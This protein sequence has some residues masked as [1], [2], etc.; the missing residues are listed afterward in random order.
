MKKL[1]LFLVI[2]LFCEWHPGLAQNPPPPDGRSP[3]E[4]IEAMKV[5]FLTNRLDLTANEAK[6]FWPVYNQYQDELEKLRKSRRDNLMNA[7]QNFDE[8]SDADVDQLIS[9]EFSFR[10]NELDIMK[11]YNPMFRKILPAKKVAK[12]YVAEE[13]F[14]R[15]LLEQLQERRDD[16]RGDGNK[17]MWKNR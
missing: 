3:R 11:K 15:K 16:R 2:L 4:K 10:Q 9:G 7:R 14:K 13:D 5:G 17:G 12:L 6:E 1:R 8:M